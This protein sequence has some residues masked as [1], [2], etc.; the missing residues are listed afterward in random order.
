[1]AQASS[2]TARIFRV[3]AALLL[4]GLAAQAGPGEPFGLATVAAPEGPLSASWRKLQRQMKTEQPLIARCRAEPHA[5]RS[6]A[7]LRFVA[8]V[9]EGKRHEGLARI[10]N[11]NRAVNL[12]IRAF[13]NAEP[14]RDEWTSPLAALAAGAGDC[15]Q[16][17][18]VKYAV[19]GDAGF[20]ADELRLVILQVKP[21]R[22]RHAVIALRHEGQWLILD[23]RTLSLVDSSDVLGHYV[24]LYAL[25]ERGVRQ[26]GTRQQPEQ[27]VA[28]VPCDSGT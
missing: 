22:D 17:A 21:G 13:N 12:A 19:L 1:M 6:T 23:N 20:S 25:D 28:S 16:Y 15:K 8:I 10:G 11:I 7:A 9:N 24:P 14:H 18:V 3:A 5:C 4:L 26:F 2:R 27:K